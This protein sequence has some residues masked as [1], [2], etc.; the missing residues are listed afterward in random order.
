MGISERATFRLQMLETADW[1]WLVLQ[2]ETAGP[3]AQKCNWVHALES[4]SH[5]V[6]SDFL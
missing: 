6:M 3:G 1:F 2:Q 4:V 5:S